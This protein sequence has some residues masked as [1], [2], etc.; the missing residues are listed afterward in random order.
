MARQEY[1]HSVLARVEPQPLER[2][3][4]VIHGAGVRSVDEDLRFAWGHLQ[5]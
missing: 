5:T 3:V 1:F 4:E 2:S